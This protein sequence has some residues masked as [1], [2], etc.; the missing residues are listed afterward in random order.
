MSE[1]IRLEDKIAE[2]E[3]EDNE[4]YYFNKLTNFVDK[5]EGYRTTNS[6]EDLCDYI[7][8]KRDNKILV[9]YANLDIAIEVE[10]N[11]IGIYDEI[12]GAIE[13]DKGLIYVAKMN[14]EGEL[15]LI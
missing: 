2:I 3:A 12:Y 5:D 14:E 8:C 7:V 1:Y 15:E 4:C 10:G 11:D 6:V 9:L 13:T